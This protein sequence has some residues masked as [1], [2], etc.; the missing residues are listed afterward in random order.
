M[1]RKKPNPYITPDGFLCPEC[2]ELCTIVPL[3]NSFDY[4]GTHCNNGKS[5]TH[6]PSD[7]GTPVSDCCEA[8]IFDLDIKGQ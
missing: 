3:D 7:Y 5:G 8:E 4:P 2:N 1:R 6:Y